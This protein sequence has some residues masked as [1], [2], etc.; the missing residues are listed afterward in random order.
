METESVKIAIS[1][2][3]GKIYAYNNQLLNQSEKSLKSGEIHKAVDIFD[4]YITSHAQ[5]YLKILYF[6]NLFSVGFLFNI[7]C[8]MEGLA[9]KRMCQ[10][11]KISLIQEELLQKQVFLIEYRYYHNSYVEDILDEILIQDKLKK[12][13]SMRVIF[14]NSV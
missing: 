10:K 12:I 9:L 7:R 1:K 6:D 2:L 3:Y 13:G 4:F 11:G 8:M 5:A 14:I